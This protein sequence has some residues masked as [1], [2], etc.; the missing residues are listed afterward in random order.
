MQAELKQLK[1]VD[2]PQN[3]RDIEEARGHGDLSENA[4]YHAA[5][6]QQ[7]FIAGNIR[8]LEDRLARVEVI[9]PTKLSGSRVVFAA[10]VT[11]FDLDKEEEVKY[12]I[13]GENEADLAE[14]KIS[15]GSPVARALIGKEIGDEAIVRAPGGDREYEV[16]DVEF[17]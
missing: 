9:D 17:I 16:V 14:G 12:Q 5:K 10:T 6:E 2:R 7:A 4:E 13:V 15:I 3:S 11:L 1:E 8:I